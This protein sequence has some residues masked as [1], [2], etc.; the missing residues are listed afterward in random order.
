MGNNGGTHTQASSLGPGILHAGG[1]HNHHAH[2]SGHHAMMGPLSDADFNFATRG[3]HGNFID[4][5]TSKFAC[6]MHF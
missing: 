4:F 3:N 2:N 6:L 1:S 5:E